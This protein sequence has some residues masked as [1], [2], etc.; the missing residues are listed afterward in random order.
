MT[1]STRN[2]DIDLSTSSKTASGN[3][4]QQMLLGLVC[5]AAIASPMSVWTLFTKPLAA[6]LGISL[7]ELQVTFSFLIV[8]QTLVSP[9]QGGLIARFGPR[10]I[11][12]A[13]TLL[14]G[15]S[16]VLAS[17]A[18]STAMLYLSY[19]VLGGLGTG[20]V[21]VGCIGLMVQWFPK[22]RGMA[23]G[24]IAA[25]Y[26][27]G[28]ILTTFP[29]AASL[30]KHGL[31]STLWLYGI[32]FAAV[33]L[34]AAQG[35]RAP[36]AMAMP[37][38]QGSGDRD[39]SPAQMLKSP[40]FWLMFVMM[41]MMCSSGLMVTSQLATFA[42]DFGVSNVTVFGLAAVPLAMTIDRFANG[43]T[44]PLFGLI[45]DRF[46]REQTMCFAFAL[47]AVAMALWLAMRNDPL[48]FAVLS[49]VVFF[50]WGEIFSLFPA[51]LADTFGSRHA[52]AN[53]G[54]LYISFGI[55]SIVGGPLA[56]LLH[57]QTGSWIP[58]FNAAITLDIV[59]ALL[60]I[61]L[62][63]PLRA[64]FMARRLGAGPQ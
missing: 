14:S 4:W 54:C 15:L 32:I 55:G 52:T 6:K 36:P 63:K 51:T 61:L 48:L 8:L 25:G 29:I 21:Y 60:A 18:Q 30:E 42:R 34:L 17:Q 20:T 7:P 44:R 1:T 41:T 23:A 11:I 40:V 46:G 59:T 43:L 26:G 28:A 37:D 24:V 22:H 38:S 27:M 49:G 10:W 45:S 58:V 13:G 50:G 19:G 57:D 16:W 33:G 3:R 53:Y 62:L 31:D 9:F 39:W 12:S 64:S 56:S 47:E 35:L 2:I 5:M